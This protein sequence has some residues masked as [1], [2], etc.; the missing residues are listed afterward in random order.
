MEIKLMESRRA[1][2]L[3][4][5][6]FSLEEPW[7]SRFLNLIVDRAALSTVDGG[8]PSQSTVEDWLQDPKL[9]N[10]VRHLLGTWTHSL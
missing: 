3:A 1:S 9:Y 5:R 7:R 6:I 10:Q 8:A 4:E 2:I